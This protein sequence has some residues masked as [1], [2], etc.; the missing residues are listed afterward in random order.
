MPESNQDP[1]SRNFIEDVEER[2]VKIV[3]HQQDDDLDASAKEYELPALK[4]WE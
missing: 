4:L 1:I 3:V 2:D